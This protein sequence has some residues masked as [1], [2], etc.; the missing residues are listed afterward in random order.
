MYF[1]LSTSMKAKFL[2]PIELKSKVV[3]VQDP[4][5][6][7][8]RV[9]A[10]VFPESRYPGGVG[11]QTWR[12]L[13]AQAQIN[14]KISYSYGDELISWSITNNRWE[15]SNAYQGVISFSPENVLL[16]ELVQNWY[17]GS[18]VLDSEVDVYPYQE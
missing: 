10:V 4:I 13:D 3:I 11:G 2:G 17:Y 12:I 9:Y 1:L 15:I 7:A 5:I 6:P 14:G 18:N 16:P 8:A